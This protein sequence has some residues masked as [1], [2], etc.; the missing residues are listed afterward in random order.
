M[1][2]P[3]LLSLFLASRSTLQQEVLQ[4]THARRVGVVGRQEDFESSTCLA[5]QSRGLLP[6]PLTEKAL[7][8]WQRCFARKQGSQHDVG[9][10]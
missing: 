8:G 7:N 1:L 6:P 10:D 4:S 3:Q 2:T 9:R 5:A